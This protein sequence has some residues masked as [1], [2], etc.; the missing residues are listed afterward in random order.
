VHAGIILNVV[1]GVLGSSQ[2]VSGYEKM[3]MELAWWILVVP[4]R[5]PIKM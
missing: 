3:L 1:D 2:K 4:S 5:I